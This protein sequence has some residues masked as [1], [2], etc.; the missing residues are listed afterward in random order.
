MLIPESLYLRDALL[1]QGVFPQA[2][3]Q[4][5]STSDT[6]TTVVSSFALPDER[7]LILTT[8]V[9][10]KMLLRIMIMPV[11]QPSKIG[12]VKSARNNLPMVISGS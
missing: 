7:D 11:L 1:K 3:Y 12:G 6:A 10:S 2:E 8:G 4:L 9:C 5:V